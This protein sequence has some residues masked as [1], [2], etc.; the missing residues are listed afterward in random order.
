MGLDFSHGEAHWA[1]SAFHRFREGVAK[2]IG[3]DLNIMKGYGFETPGT[4]SW[5][6]LKPDPIHALLDHSDCD[7]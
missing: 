2:A 6:M 5:E 1:Y 7:G 3:L 4:M